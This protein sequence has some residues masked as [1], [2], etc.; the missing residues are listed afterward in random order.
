M[1]DLEHRVS[2][3]WVVDSYLRTI[4]TTHLGVPG[5]LMGVACGCLAGWPAGG[6]FHGSFPFPVSDMPAA[7][8]MQIMHTCTQF[9]SWFSSRNATVAT[10]D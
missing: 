9:L 8:S 1:T 4:G 2:L 7:M 3:V 6:E 5:R 10:V